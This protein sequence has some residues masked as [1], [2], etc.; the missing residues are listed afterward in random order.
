[1]SRQK[2]FL[3]IIYLCA[4]ELNKQLPTDTQ[5]E[6][7]EYT[8]IIGKNSSLDSLGIVTLIV[9]IEEKIRLLGIDFDLIDNL[10]YPSHET[11]SN[12]T[13]LDIARFIDENS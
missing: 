4:Q 5:L 13:M 10:V 8:P 2:E 12:L 7:S 11:R 3:D 9:A 6:L 1:M